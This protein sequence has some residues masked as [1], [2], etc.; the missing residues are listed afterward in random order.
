MGR[1]GSTPAILLTSSLK[2]HGNGCHFQPLTGREKMRIHTN[3]GMSLFSGPDFRHPL[4]PMGESR[5][6][7]PHLFSLGR[8]EGFSRQLSFLWSPVLSHP[9]SPGSLLSL[10]GHL[11]LGGLLVWGFPLQRASFTFP[12]NSEP[13]TNC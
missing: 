7:L 9:D 4:K 12:H 5:L 11:H 10:L 1:E 13:F 6:T 3:T 8:H 2:D